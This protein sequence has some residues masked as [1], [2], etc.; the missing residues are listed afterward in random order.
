MGDQPAFQ[1]RLDTA[2]WDS[3]QNNAQNYLEQLLAIQDSVQAR[4]LLGQTLF[5]QEKFAES[6]KAVLP[7]YQ[8]IQ[9]RDAGKLLA[10]NYAHLKNW[11]SA[12]FYLEE[13][14]KSATELSVLNLAAE[15][16]IN[17]DQHLSDLKDLENN[18]SQ[19]F[20]KVI[21]RIKSAFLSGKPDED[22][23]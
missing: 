10:A 18:G 6:I 22:N 19:R 9:D 7:V 17:L 23:S 14:L 3:Y 16:Y 13:L 20:S 8:A 5:A 1:N 12:L 21:Q 15:C 11:A 2:V 4:L